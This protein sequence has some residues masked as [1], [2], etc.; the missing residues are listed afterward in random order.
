MASTPGDFGKSTSHLQCTAQSKRTGQRCKGPA[1]Y[2][3][4]TQKCRMHGGG[5]GIGAENPAFK[6]GRY[7]RYLPSDMLEL[8]SSALSNPDILEMADHIALLEARIQKILADNQ[9]GD[10]VPR[11]SEILDLFNSI[12]A[13]VDTGDRG[14]I[15][16]AFDSARKA[17]HAGMRWDSTWNQVADTMEQLRKM[18]DT[19]IKRK[20]E[21]NQMVPIERIV[22]LMA[23]VAAA[24]K[25]NVTNPDE[26]AKVHNE[27]AVL[28][29]TNKTA[30]DPQRQRVGPEVIDVSPHTRGTK[31]GRSAKAFERRL[32]KEREATGGIV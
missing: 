13:M 25:R 20:R 24:V 17:L 8:Y 12:E 31:G 29:G 23:A 9:G 2:G 27:L 19:E 14:L 1:I 7:S 4:R 21:L 18:T 26:I 15:A 11:W 32:K 30:K 6:S 16:G 22:I 5:A 10:P 3:S 28:L